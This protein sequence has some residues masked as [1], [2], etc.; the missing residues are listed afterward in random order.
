MVLGHSASRLLILVLLLLLLLL[1]G[2]LL[3]KTD[4]GLGKHPPA[5]G[6][7]RGISVQLCICILAKR[8]RKIS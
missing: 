1:L 7:R 8:A 2:Q 5:K 6:G 3:L 4:A